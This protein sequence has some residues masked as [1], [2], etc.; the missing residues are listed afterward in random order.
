MPN[1]WGLNEALAEIDEAM[2]PLDGFFGSVD[3]LNGFL[4]QDVPLFQCDGPGVPMGMVHC[5]IP[6]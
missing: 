4:R 3:M 5:I 2:L 6:A 1:S